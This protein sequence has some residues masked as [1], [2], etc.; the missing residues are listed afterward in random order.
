L[1]WKR[2]NPD[3]NKMIKNIESLI[4]IF[5]HSVA[6]HGKKIEKQLKKMKRNF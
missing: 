5:G 1:V 6:N 2:A 3:N 4:N